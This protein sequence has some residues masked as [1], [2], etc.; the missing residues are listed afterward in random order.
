VSLPEPLRFVPLYGLFALIQRPP[1][2]GTFDRQRIERFLVVLERVLND[3]FGLFGSGRMRLLE[4]ATKQLF[5]DGCD[6]DA[7]CELFVKKM[8]QID[9]E[10]PLPRGLEAFLKRAFV[11]SIDAAL[12]NM[13]YLHPTKCDFMA[14]LSWNTF[15]GRV[16]FNTALPLDFVRFTEAVSVIQMTQLIDDDPKAVNDIC[17]HLPPATVLALLSVRE[18]DDDLRSKPDAGKFARAHG[19]DLYRDFQPTTVDTK[20]LFASGLDEVRLDGWKRITV[21]DAILRECDFL[22]LCLA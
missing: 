4:P 18:V 10:L 9:T 6:P 17:P 3:T 20:G 7:A 8:R 16:R 1:I 21:P 5:Q 13:I 14:S 12:V 2:S 22:R 11:E 19:L 15:A